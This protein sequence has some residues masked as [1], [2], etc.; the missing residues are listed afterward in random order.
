MDSATSIAGVLPDLDAVFCK[1][2]TTHLQVHA[3]MVV[4]VSSF[5]CEWGNMFTVEKRLFLI[6]VNQ[7]ERVVSSFKPTKQN[8]TTSNIV[9]WGGGY[10]QVLLK[11]KVQHAVILCSCFR[12][13]FIKHSP[14]FSIN[15]SFHHDFKETLK[16]FKKV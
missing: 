2:Q 5:S 15:S 12:L 10:F 3:K 11:N 1:Q 16:R 13:V 7:S 9:S 6:P 8:K 14:N 4:M